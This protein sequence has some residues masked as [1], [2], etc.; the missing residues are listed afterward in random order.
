ME[1]EGIKYTHTWEEWR[2]W[3]AKIIKYLDETYGEY[4]DEKLQEFFGEEESSEEE[5]EEMKD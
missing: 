2:E 1:L 5:D 3:R 4:L